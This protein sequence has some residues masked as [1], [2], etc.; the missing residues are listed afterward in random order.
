MHS[1][2]AENGSQCSTGSSIRSLLQDNSSSMNLRD[3]S[4]SKTGLAV[5]LSSRTQGKSTPEEEPELRD[6]ESVCVVSTPD[7][8]LELV[9]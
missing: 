8:I 7:G 5:R 4:K 1:N 9:F 3:L 6:S 2:F